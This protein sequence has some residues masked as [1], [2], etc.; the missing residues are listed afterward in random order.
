[1]YTNNYIDTS[2]LQVSF[3]Y[4]RNCQFSYINYG[5]YGNYGNYNGAGVYGYGNGG[6]GGGGGGGYNYN[7]NYNA[8]EMT[9][10]QSP[11][12]SALYAYKEK[13]GHS[14]KKNAKKASKSSSYSGSS[15]YS[16]YSAPSVAS[17]SNTGSSFSS[18]DDV[19]IYLKSSYFGSCLS[20]VSESFDNV[21]SAQAFE[22]YIC[23]AYLSV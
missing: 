16:S 8:G 19:Y 10:H 20:Q 17:S 2:T 7:Y 21:K 15:R 23:N 6:G 18:Y 4:C 14:C 3:D 5:N 11:L 1:M 12:C 22:F 9:L 13:C